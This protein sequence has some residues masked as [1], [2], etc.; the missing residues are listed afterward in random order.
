MSSTQTRPVPGLRLRPYSGEPDLAAIARI[1]N[2]EAE[3]DRVPERTTVGAL[4]ARFGN[5]GEHFEPGRDV[6]VAEIDSQPVAVAM[7]EWV[8]TTDGAR[9]YRADG[10]VDPAWRRR[11]VGAALLA[12]NERRLGALAAS[13]ATSRPRVLGSW[14]GDSQ[15]GDAAVLRA[16]GYEAVRWFFDMNRP[17]LDAVPDLPLPERL[18]LRPITRDSARAVWFASIDAFRDHWGGFD[19]SEEHLQSWLDDPTTDLS[20]WLIAFDGDEVAGGVINAIDPAENAALGIQRG[21][22]SSVFTRRAWRQR[23]LA[24]GL[25]ARS[26]VLLRE[27][28]MT[29]AGLGVDADNQSGALGLYERLGFAVGYRSTAWRKPLDPAVPSA[30]VAEAGRAE[31]HR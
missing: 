24:R 3:A 15:V 20:L 13:H 30:A 1:E 14:S 26:L 19:P 10:A 27:R 6:T 25:I 21:W 8:D 2:L 17:N 7:R 28:G 9:E 4:A 5:P 31:V 22:L 11:G 29:T 23:G 12:E 18:E 16:A